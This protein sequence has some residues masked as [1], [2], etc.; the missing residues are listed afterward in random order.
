[1]SQSISDTLT[2]RITDAEVRA[3]FTPDFIACVEAIERF[4]NETV[5]DVVRRLDLEAPLARGST[6]PALLAERG[7]AP[8]SA[9]VLE[10]F[11]RKLAGEGLLDAEE[12][13]A[14]TRYRTRGPLP[15]GDPAVHEARAGG[16][17]PGSLATFQ[18]VSGILDQVPAMMRGEATAEEVLFAP[19]RI[20]LWFEY[21]SND[22]LLYAISNRLGAEA[23][24]RALPATRP[25]AVLELGGGSGSAALA[26]AERLA[27]DGSAHRLQ[28]WTLT[29]VVPTFLRRAERAV[30]AAYPGWPHEFK[31]LDIDRDFSQQGV[32]PESAD[33]VYA[34]NTVHI[35]RDLPAT[36]RQIHSTLKPGGRLVLSECV[37]PRPGQAL[38]VEFVFNFLDNFTHVQTDPRIRPDHGFLAP[39]HWRASLAEAGFEDVAL[40]PD[41]EAI[42]PHFPLFF[43]AAVTA[44][45]RA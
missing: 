39:V 5:V 22:N 23:L 16:I 3:L 1:V 41:I 21:F 43:A 18:I 37:R 27:R 6:V 28:R 45:R 8:R 42:S 36:L 19:G 35:A 26:A 34:V 4:T 30:K 2:E 32:A 38:Y 25:G 44:R 7:F 12:T 11:L 9:F 31:R 24:V 20:S 33:V 13:V 17:S 29:D 15:V 14:G 10:W 40:L